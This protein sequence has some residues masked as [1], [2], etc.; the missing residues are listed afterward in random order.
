M[1]TTDRMP[2]LNSQRTITDRIG[3]TVILG[4]AVQAAGVNEIAAASA[5]FGGASTAAVLFSI[6]PTFVMNAVNGSFGIWAVFLN[7]NAVSNFSAAGAS[8]RAAAM[9]EVSAA[10]L[11][12][13]TGSGGLLNVQTFTATGGYTPTTGTVSVVVECLGGGGGGGGCSATSGT[14]SEGSGGGAGALALSNRITSGFSGV[15]VT[16]GA[17]GAGGAAG[18]N[19]GTAGGATSF[20]TL[21]VGGGGGGGLGDTAHGITSALSGG[22]G[23]SASGTAST[24]G[25]RGQQGGLS[26]CLDGNSTFGGFG[27]STLY[28]SGGPQNIHGTSSAGVGNAAT[29]KGCGGGGASSSGTAASAA[30]G[31]GTDGICIVYEYNV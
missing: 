29:G 23:G 18:A 30:G 12:C 6:L 2:N 3:E 21:L 26:L 5:G 1:S 22:A 16:I 17:G 24:G 7:I 25:Y 13:Q 19:N 9:A 20:G 31:A 11:T 8:I 15:T 14:A 10:A 28:G 27:G 4:N